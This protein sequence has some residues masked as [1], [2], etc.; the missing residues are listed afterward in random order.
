M[1]RGEPKDPN[2]PWMTVAEVAAELR[3][4][5]ATI[6]LWISKGRPLFVAADYPPPTWK[7]KWVGFG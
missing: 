6:R 4:N 1:Q 2:D 3:L 7:Y 5:P